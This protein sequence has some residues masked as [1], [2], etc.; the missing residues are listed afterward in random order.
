MACM[1]GGAGAQE[2]RQEL[3]DF[4]EI[5]KGARVSSPLTGE[6]Q[7][8]AV[9]LAERRLRSDKL[10]PERKTVL[11]LVQIHRNLEA[12]KRGVFQRHALLT[13]YRYAGDLGILVYVNLARQQVTTVEQIPHFPAPLA[14]EEFQRARELAFND[15]QLKKVF[16]RFRNRVTV[17]AI[18]AGRAT[19]KDPFYGHR[20]VFL[21]FRVGPLYLTEQGA[22]TVDLTT[23]KVFIAPARHEE[24]SGRH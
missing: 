10:L 20:L 23:E 14:P 17:E 12:E 13:F 8:L 21:L 11:T 3:P 6:E 19:P 2:R 18:M 7:D 22:V 15:P 24:G 1:C 5:L 16:D 9:R 4:E